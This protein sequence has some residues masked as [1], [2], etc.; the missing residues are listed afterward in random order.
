MLDSTKRGEPVPGLAI[1]SGVTHPV[2]VIVCGLVVELA[3]EVV[4]GGVCAATI[5]I[6]TTSPQY[7]GSRFFMISPSQGRRVARSLTNDAL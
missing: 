6:D 5:A 3:P 2:T 1:V 7:I 4:G